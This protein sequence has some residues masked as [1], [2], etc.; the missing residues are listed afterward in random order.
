M[1]YYGKLSFAAT[2][3]NSA[4]AD[5][6]CIALRGVDFDLRSVKINIVKSIVSFQV[7][8]HTI[9]ASFSMLF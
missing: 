1:T 7:S 8:S 9:K 4:C 5:A 6:E 2:S 3:V